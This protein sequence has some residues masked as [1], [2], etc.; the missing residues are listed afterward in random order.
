VNLL[1]DTHIAI[2]AVED[3]PRLPKAARALILDPSASLFVGVVS[4]WEIAIKHALG[5]GAESMPMPAANALAF[6]QAS[7]FVLLPVTS[8]HVLTLETLPR[9]HDDPFD[10]LLVATALTEPYR[11]VTHD[12]RLAA[13]G[14]TVTVV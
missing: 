6:F 1:L 10:R 5:R 8:A 9:H 3:N 11:L 7:G 2:W 4:L 14:P 13:Y 12:A